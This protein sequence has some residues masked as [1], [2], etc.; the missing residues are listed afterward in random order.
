M[1]MPW[2]S[3]LSAK[4][5]QQQLLNSLQYHTSPGHHAGV[6]PHGVEGLVCTWHVYVDTTAEDLKPPQPALPLLLPSRLQCPCIA[7]F[8]CTD[9]PYSAYTIKSLLGAVLQHR[10]RCC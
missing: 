9:S 10:L 3:S 7:K 5:M 4:T 2:L 8:G 6:K 1:E